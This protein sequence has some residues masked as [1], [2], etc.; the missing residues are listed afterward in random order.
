VHTANKLW[1]LAAVI[2]EMCTLFDRGSMCM[3]VCFCWHLG[4]LCLYNLV[5]SVLQLWLVVMLIYVTNIYTL[6][7]KQ[8]LVGKQCRQQ[9][10]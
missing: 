4:F 8:E 5:N 1:A 10:S 9:D 6:S 7:V 2:V 3:S